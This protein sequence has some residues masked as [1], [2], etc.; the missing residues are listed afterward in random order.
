M[1]ICVDP[2]HGGKDPGAVDHGVQEDDL[3]LA[4]ALAFGAELKPF[5]EGLGFQVLLTRTADVALAADPN[6]DLRARSDAANKWGADAC[7]SI[8]CNA[9]GTADPRHTAQGIETYAMP[10][11]RGEALAR[12][13]HRYT[14]ALSGAKDR[15][16]RTDRN[17]AMLRRTIMPAVLLELGYMTNAGEVVLLQKP[18]YRAR[19]QLGIVAG[20]LAWAPGR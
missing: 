19:L 10:G 2:G 17:F 9:S 1:K 14:V 8:H 6:A 3:N 20:L 13:I 16:V 11:G 4:V 15:G 18:L 12:H 5:L 7:L